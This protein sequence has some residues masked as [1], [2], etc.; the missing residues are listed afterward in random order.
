[1]RRAARGQRAVEPGT[2]DVS[3]GPTIGECARKAIRAPKINLWR[4]VGVRVCGCVS[5]CVC[6]CVCVCVWV[7]GDGAGTAGRGRCRAC[8]P[9]SAGCLRAA[10]SAATTP[11]TAHATTHATAPATPKQFSG[12][13]RSAAAP[14]RSAPGAPAPCR[15]ARSRGECNRILQC[16][17]ISRG[18]AIMP[19]YRAEMPSGR[20]SGRGLTRSGQTLSPISS[21]E[22]ARTPAYPRPSLC[23]TPVLSLE[24]PTTGFPPGNTCYRWRGMAAEWQSRRR[25]GEPGR[26]CT[27]SG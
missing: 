9:P 18:N 14:R 21:P 7:G 22:I 24:T 8:R 20:G 11:A 6:V 12:R 25:L 13:T 10:V 4:R 5:V 27:R 2:P 3:G 15:P 1:M 16:S 26:L 19:S 17:G 23:D